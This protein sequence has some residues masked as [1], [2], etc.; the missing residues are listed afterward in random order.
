MLTPQELA[1]VHKFIGLVTGDRSCLSDLQRRWLDT[2]KDTVAAL[3][4]TERLSNQCHWAVATWG[5]VAHKYRPS[6]WSEEDEL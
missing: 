6:W 1:T 5:A 3:H 4:V 2:H